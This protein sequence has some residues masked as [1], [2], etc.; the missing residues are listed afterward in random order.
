[1]IE[2]NVP[3]SLTLIEMGGYYTEYA[4]DQHIEDIEE[5]SGIIQQRLKD[6]RKL[7]ALDF[8]NS[9]SM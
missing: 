9:Q 1:M 3:K 6:L 7:K 8:V 4:A 5:V 2:V